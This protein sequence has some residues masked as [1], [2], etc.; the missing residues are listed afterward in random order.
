[1]RRSLVASP[2]VVNGAPV[3][4]CSG[5]GLDDPDEVKGLG[6]DDRRGAAQDRPAGT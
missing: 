5:R 3:W 1:M 4:Q 6:V 2:F